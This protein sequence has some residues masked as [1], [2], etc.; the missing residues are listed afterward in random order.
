[1]GIDALIY[2]PLFV[3]NAILLAMTLFKAR[4]H[5][6]MRIQIKLLSRLY[7]DAFIFSGLV[8]AGVIITLVRC[9]MA[10]VRFRLVLLHDGLTRDRIGTHY[11][12][13]AFRYANC[14]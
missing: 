6:R 2:F 11:V 8:G 12:L 13:A 14:A 3:F 5:Y 10:M 9:M 1:M 4:Q 7:R